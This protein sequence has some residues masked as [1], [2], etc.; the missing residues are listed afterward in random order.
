MFGLLTAAFF[1]VSASSRDF[2]KKNHPRIRRSHHR[3]LQIGTTEEFFVLLHL[4]IESV[5]DDL[6][7]QFEDPTSRA[8]THLCNSVNEQVRCSVCIRF[9]V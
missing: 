8:V 4:S 3:L 7:S 2:E 1:Y 5:D 6:A 9:R